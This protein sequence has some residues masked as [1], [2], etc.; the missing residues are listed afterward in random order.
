M[1]YF[2]L[3]LFEFHDEYDDEWF[4]E[5]PYYDEYDYRVSMR[6]HYN[7][8]CRSDKMPFSFIFRPILT[9]KKP[10]WKVCPHFKPRYFHEITIGK[11][12]PIL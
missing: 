1:A 9:P 6:K 4:D 11:N 8:K 5:Y 3:D 10:D 2:D 12:R 7:V